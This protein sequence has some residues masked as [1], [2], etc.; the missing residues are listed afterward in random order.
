MKIR[1]ERA[2]LLHADE[3]TDGRTDRHDK[4]HSCS[5]QFCERAQK[6]HLL[7]VQNI[8]SVRFKNQSFN[9]GSINYWY[10]F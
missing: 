1:P 8:T 9:I 4:S 6:F 3:R 2:E 7:L 5:S 10:V